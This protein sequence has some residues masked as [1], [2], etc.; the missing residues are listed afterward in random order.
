MFW[1]DRSNARL[2]AIVQYAYQHPW[3]ARWIVNELLPAGGDQTYIQQGN[4]GGTGEFAFMQ[5]VYAPYASSA[6]KT[7][8]LNLM[9]NDLPDGCSKNGVEVSAG[10]PGVNRVV[11]SGTVGSTTNDTTHI[12]LASSASATTN[13]YVGAIV[14]YDPATSADM[15]TIGCWGRVT[16]YNGTTKVATV[17]AAWQ[18]NTSTGAGCSQP[19]AGYLYGVYASVIWSSVTALGSATVTGTL[20]QFTTDAAVGSTLLG[21]TGWYVGGS[22]TVV[23]TVGCTVTAIADNTHLTCA[24]GAG[25]GGSLTGIWGPNTTDPVIEWSL[26]AMTNSSC[27][28]FWALNHWNNVPGS[29]PVSYPPEGGDLVAE[30]GIP[31]IGSNNAQFAVTNHA[32]MDI[33]AAP[34]DSR[35]ITDLAKLTS[36][37]ADPIVGHMMGYSTGYAHSGASYSPGVLGTLTAYVI[38]MSK[39]PG[40]PSLFPTT[41]YL[42]AFSQYKMYTALPEVQNWASIGNDI[43]PARW[44]A[45]DGFDFIDTSAGG[46]ASDANLFFAP[47]STLSTQFKNWANHIMHFDLLGRYA[48]GFTASADFLL[49]VDPRIGSLNYNTLPLQYAFTTTSAANCAAFLGTGSLCNNGNFGGAV[50]SRTGWG[51][52]DGSS[53]VRGGLSSSFLQFS[54]RGF[55]DDHD[56]PEAGQLRLYKVGQV[57]DTD[58]SPAGNQTQVSDMSILGDTFQ[59]GG[60]QGYWGTEFLTATYNVP[61]QFGTPYINR[62]ASVGN[63]SYGDASSRYVYTCAETAGQFQ[64]SWNV[65]SAMRCIAHF[66]KSGN[67]EFIFQWDTASTS[68]STTGGIKTNVHYAQNGQNQGI[69]G[70]YTSGTT[71]CNGACSSLNT[72]RAT[73]STPAIVSL[74]DGHAADDNPARIF[75]V[76]SAF[77]SPST[78]FVHWDCPGGGSAP[79]CSP[80]STY[81]GGAGYTDRVSICADPSSTGACGATASG[82]ESLVVHKV[83]NGSGSTGA[84][85]TDTTLTTTALN[86]DANWTGA[87]SCGAVGCGVFIGARGGITHSTMAAFTT[88]HSGTA[89]YLIGGLTPGTYTVTVGGSAISACNGVAGGTCTVGVNDTSAY[90]ESTAGSRLPC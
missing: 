7:T 45:E 39:V 71:T 12:T 77:L 38:T 84:P 68:G 54:G 29:Q 33:A 50:V 43:W 58:G 34:D 9:Y 4:Y 18:G 63:G 57:L 30:L 82:F 69:A 37:A 64:P 16:A 90:F 66:K 24:N 49:A 47:T 51:N 83:V 35:A 21:V 42:S 89:Q 40:Y 41:P 56:N 14:V 61:N 67:D 44:G 80:G 46:Y 2:F 78:N 27:G 75:G 76:V 31:L 28:M 36:Y 81:S 73:L 53:L 88:T 10:T 79:Q 52:Y 5:A 74:E 60:D 86:P 17:N 11:N 19:T 8:F 6:S 59:F 1:A 22:S 15:P 65:L 70:G 87:Q 25:M 85:S 26:P 48:A 20:T 32:A 55:A 3:L 62:W 23:T 13:Y 72:A